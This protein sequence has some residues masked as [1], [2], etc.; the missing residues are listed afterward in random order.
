MLLIS[1][2][3][4]NGVFL[5]LSLWPLLINFELIFH[6]YQSVFTEW[7][8]WPID[9]V[10]SLAEN[11]RLISSLVINGSISASEH[12]LAL[13]LDRGV[14]NYWITSGSG[15]ELLQVLNAFTES[16]PFVLDLTI[17]WK[18]CLRKF[19]DLALV[20][21][22][23]IINLIVVGHF[24]TLDVSVTTSLHLFL[25]ESLFFLST[26]KLFTSNLWLVFVVVDFKLFFILIITHEVLHTDERVSS[27][28]VLD[29]CVPFSFNP[30]LLES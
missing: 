4:S 12:I 24:F 7:C 9:E 13:I 28:L 15:S 21:I 29:H 20:R 16:G 19:K 10:L 1:G 22:V 6:F 14:T 8:I 30:V 17:N 27:L 23:V 25:P 11:R 26:T 2:C 18:W 3:W 5:D